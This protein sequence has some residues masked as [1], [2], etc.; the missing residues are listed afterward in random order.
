M[1][2]HNFGF[3]WR[4][5]N[6]FYFSKSHRGHRSFISSHSKVPQQHLRKQQNRCIVTNLSM[7]TRVN[8]MCVFYSLQAP[9]PHLGDLHSP[10]IM[11]ISFFVR[12]KKRGFLFFS[13]SFSPLKTTAEREK[14]GGKSTWRL[15]TKRACYEK[16]TVQRCT[17]G[18]MLIDPFVSS[19]YWCIVVVPRSLTQ[20]ARRQQPPSYFTAQRRKSILAFSMV[21]FYSCWSLKL[22]DT[23]LTM[24][25]RF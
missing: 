20:F 17:S 16:Y 19:F 3:C 24:A 5:R 4:G 6:V 14:G 2:L 18:T 15:T 21:S 23:A 8:P 25:V 10:A 22:I 1:K 9:P 11:A 12:R 7:H 13:L